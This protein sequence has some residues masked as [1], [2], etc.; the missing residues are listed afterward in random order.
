MDFPIVLGPDGKPVF[1]GREDLSNPPV[2]PSGG[3]KMECPQCHSMVDYLVGEN[4]NG[5][6]QGC[7]GCYKP[8]VTP[9][10]GTQESYDT[11]KEML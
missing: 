5:G 1:V 7:E 4:V 9:V 10:K 11:S 8:P 3:S 6:L 2:S